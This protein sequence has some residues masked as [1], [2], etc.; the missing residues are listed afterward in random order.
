MA[1]FSNVHIVV[2]YYM[3]YLILDLKRSKILRQENRTEQNRTEQNSSFKL[4]MK[5]EHLSK[6]LENRRS[7]L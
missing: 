7:T 3:D 1:E 6:L 2:S 5:K 4:R